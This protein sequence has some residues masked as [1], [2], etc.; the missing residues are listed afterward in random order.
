MKS[1]YVDLHIHIGRTKSGKAVKITGARTLTLENVLRIS[2]ERKGLDMI[3]VIDCHSPEV[4]EEIEGLIRKEEISENPEGGLQYGTTTLI[5]GSE[6]EVYDG[7][8]KGPIHVLA[9]FPTLAIMKEFSAWMSGYVSNITLSSQRI[10]CDA[11]T[12]QQTV[13]AL[14]GL[15]IPAHVFTPFKSLYGKGVDKSLE[16]VLDPALIDGVELGLSSDTSMAVNISE[17]DQFTFLTNSDAH[18]LNKIARE[19]QKMKLASPNFTELEKAMKEMDGRRISAN[20]GLNPWLGKY[21]RTVCKTCLHPV[22]NAD[23]ICPEC[24][25]KKI[26]KGVSS[27]IKELSVGSPPTNLRERPPY[28]HQVPLE[29]IPGLGPKSMDRLLQA[30]GTEMDILHRASLEQI[31]EAVPDKIASYIDLARKGKLEIEAG[32]GGKYGKVKT[33]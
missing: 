2:R 18:S 22:D 17:L 21:H 27:R 26:I 5:P 32:G 3:G 16:E 23:G 4:L 25:S 6:I 19:Y 15:F 8:S 30:L 31:K 33:E 12:L 10:Y 1:Y 20:Y 28:I 29:F 11:R 14:G 13:K 24:G 7:N 9:Y